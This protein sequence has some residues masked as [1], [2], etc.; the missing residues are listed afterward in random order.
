MVYPSARAVFLVTLGIPIAL[1]LALMAPRLWLAGATWILFVIGLMLLDGLLAGLPSSLRMEKWLP[2]GMAVGQISH[3]L[4]TLRFRKA[5]A[6]RNLEV[7]LDVG[8]RLEAMPS[9]QSIPIEARTAKADFGLSPRRRG[10]GRLDRV[11]IRWQGPLLLAWLQRVE[12]LNCALPIVPN[13]RSVKEEAIRLF[14]RDTPL[15]AHVELNTAEGAEFYALREFETGMDRRMIDWKQSAKHGLLLVKEFQA[16]KNQH[17]VVALDT[18]RLMSEPVSGQPRIDRALQAILLLAYVS[19]KI[20]DRVGLFAFDERPRLHSGTV[21]GLA[22]FPRLQRM[23]AQ[24][25]YSTAETNFTLGLTTLATELTHRSIIVIFT[26]FV[27]TTSAELLLENVTRLLQRHLVLFVLFRDT[28]LE[29]MVRGEPQTPEDVSR[30][31]IAD[32]I[33]RERDIVI[34]RL[35]RLGV[36]IIDAPLERIGLGLLESYLAIKRQD[37][38]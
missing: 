13:I 18:G 26:D 2:E 8:P 29:D 17:L 12:A 4:F 1:L 33:L 31:V 19:L 35:R 21:V 3:A 24:L 10:E 27:D 30:A 28:E 25:D 38:V 20:G 23:A 34:E 14:Q 15:G 6:P 7:A 36:Q 16:E 9:R 11:W 5:S 22:A 37:R 32:A